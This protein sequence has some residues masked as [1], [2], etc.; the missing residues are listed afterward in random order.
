MSTEYFAPRSELSKIIIT[1]QVYDVAENWFPDGVDFDEKNCDWIIFPRY[2]LPK[3]WHHIAKVTPLMIV[4][5]SAYPAVPPVGFYLHK[6]LKESPDGHLFQKAYH[7]ACQ[8]P[9]KKGW[10]WYCVYVNKGAWQP[11]P[12]KRSMDWKNGDNL[13][14][15]LMLCREALESED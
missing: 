8:L 2:E 11:C 10:Q 1:E 13:Y 4:F 12:V 6:N 5:P 15:Y 9:V 14:T 7:Q 3:N